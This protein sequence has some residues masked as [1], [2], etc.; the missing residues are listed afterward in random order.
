MEMWNLKGAVISSKSLEMS[1]L[2][3]HS[4]ACVEWELKALIRV[5]PVWKLSLEAHTAKSP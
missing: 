5:K 3:D 4:R 1:H 2:K